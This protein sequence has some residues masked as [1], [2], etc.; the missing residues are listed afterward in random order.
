MKKILSILFFTL[1]FIL[2]SCGGGGSSGTTSSNLI[3]IGT[4]P[5]G[6]QVYI[7]SNNLSLTSTEAQT[8]TISL[9]GGASNESFNLNFNTKQSSSIQNNSENNYGISVLPNPCILGTSG[10]LF[11]NSCKITVSVSDVTPTGK[12]TII[13]TA[14]SSAGEPS[15]ELSPINISVTHQVTPSSDN[16]ITSY[17]I[18]GVPGLFTEDSSKLNF[19]SVIMPFGTNVT[20]LVSVFTTTSGS[21]VRV[22]DIVQLSTFHF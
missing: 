8:A 9:V 2:T 21:T 11:P 1:M 13:P 4:L 12:Y 17:S 7:T 18:N 5:N 6:S 16:L 14:V 3:N 10:S 22:G 20:S 19:I 15:T